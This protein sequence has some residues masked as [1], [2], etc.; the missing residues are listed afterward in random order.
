ME[1]RPCFVEGAGLKKALSNKAAKFRITTVET[2]LFASGNLSVT[3][4]DP[5]SGEKAQ[6]EVID[7]EDNTYFVKYVC[8]T[9]GDYVLSIKAYGQEIEGSPFAVKV[10]PGPDA[11]KCK[12]SGPCLLANS[13][14]QS[15]SQLEFLVDATQAGQGS[16]VVVV[17]GK[18]EQPKVFISD[19]A[20]N[21][22][23]SVK[24]EPRLQGRYYIN[25]FYGGQHIPGS[26][27]K[28][29]IHPKP[30]AA[31]VKAFGHG[32]EKEVKVNEKAEFVIDTT[33]AGIGTLSVKVHGVKGGYNVECQPKSAE[34]PRIVIGSYQPTES[35]DYT[36]SI[37]F[38]GEN[39]PDSPFEITVAEEEEDGK[40][41][42]RSKKMTQPE[43]NPTV[44]EDPKPEDSPTIQEDPKPEKNPAVE[45]EPKSENNPT[46][47]EVSK[48]EKNEVNGTTITAES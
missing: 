14:L 36:V 21:G 34:E 43:Q 22:M 16:L 31:K 48:P 19:D 4:D 5:V 37:L 40:K 12:A 45:E 42:R 13:I 29:K 11:S 46:V 26:P 1:H 41:K 3:V 23:Y 15:E 9:T 27:F 8:P 32:L 30:S 18:Q 35:G 20:D 10:L 39:I 24:F 25:A 6:V 28:I 38:E 2:G 44:Q 17:K 33:D 7:K 47:E